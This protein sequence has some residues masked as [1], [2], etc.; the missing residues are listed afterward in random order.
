LKDIWRGIRPHSK[1]W[2]LM[3]V[4]RVFVVILVVISILWI[5]IIQASQGFTF[6]IST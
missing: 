2:E 1:E 3:V 5:P 4:G 6:R